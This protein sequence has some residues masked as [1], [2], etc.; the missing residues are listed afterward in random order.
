M[1]NIDSIAVIAPHPDDEVLGVGGTMAR[2]A[3]QGTQVNV[4]FVSGHLP[5]LY[6]IEAFKKTRAE[7]QEAMKE[8]GASH[9]KFLERPAT[10]VHVEPV[11]K[12]NKAVADFIKGAEPKI[13][14]I[15]F[16]D[17]HIDHR[18]IFDSA[19]VATRPTY[20]G[21]PKIILAYET[22]SETYWN[23]PGIEP[24]FSP[25][26]FFDISKTLDVKIKALKKYTS[27]VKGAPSR[28]PEAAMS[29]AKLR[30]SQNFCDAAEAFKAIRL[31]F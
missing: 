11:A 27:Q 29:L 24:H 30:G 28:S 9:V 26:I 12:L 15:P 23:A 21:H 17:R 3:Q 16:P 13:V 5:P 4:L 19:M 2:F 18:A 22:L 20:S 14:F 6:P 7:A 8:V 25:E 31:I 10:K 1:E